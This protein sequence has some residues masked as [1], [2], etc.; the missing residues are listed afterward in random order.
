M[1]GLASFA[2]W[3]AA[4][5]GVRFTSQSAMRF[6]IAAVASTATLGRVEAARLLLAPVQVVVNGSGFVLLPSYTQA[7]REGSLTVARV[8]RAIYVL[9]GLSAAAGVVALVIRP[10]L[11]DLLT[12]GRFDVDAASVVAWTLATI[13]F[14]VGIPTGLAVTAAR[15]SRRAFAVRAADAAIGLTV[16]ALIAAMGAT[17]WAPAGLAVGAFVG[18]AWLLR[19]VAEQRTGDEDRPGM[20]GVEAVEPDA[21]IGAEGGSVA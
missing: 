19:D 4:Q 7:V 8:R 18:A 3:R 16:A 6:I 20:T 17:E 13:G 9:G 14:A 5:V 2:S 15:R 12:A 10:W 1:R 21:S 11:S